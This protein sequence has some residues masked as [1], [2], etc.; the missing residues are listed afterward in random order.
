MYPGDGG[1]PGKTTAHKIPALVFDEL[2]KVVE[3]DWL[4]SAV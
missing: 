3:H 2:Y 4:N 1:G